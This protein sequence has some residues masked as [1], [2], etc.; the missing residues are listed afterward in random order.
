M[1]LRRALE[2]IGF[3][4]WPAEE[5]V[6]FDGWSLRFMH[7]VSRRA[8]SVW[9]DSASPATA[10]ELHARIDRVEQWYGQRSIAP[11]FQVSEL[12]RPP[13]LDAVLEARGYRRE[14]P[15]S[16]Q[17]AR[18]DAVPQTAS[19]DVRVDVRRELTPEWFDVSAHRGRFVATPD[20]Y[21]GLLDRMG[22]RACFALANARGQAAGVGLGVVDGAWMGVFSML[23]LASS[24]RIGVARAVLS[25]LARHATERGAER[26][27]LFVERDNAPARALYRGASFEEVHGYH[28]RVR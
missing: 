24:R 16:V 19:A 10:R 28:Y 18:A 15:V 20:V 5:V 3:D 25:A 13:E 26:M 11:M 14:A 1:D 27:Y 7:G 2:R 21:R 22:S 12:S 23:T 6:D 9:P 17:I 4:A 8:N